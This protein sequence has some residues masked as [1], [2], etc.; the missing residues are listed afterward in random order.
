MGVASQF[1]RLTSRS[2][3]FQAFE[4]VR[5]R[6][7]CRGCDGVSL[8]SFERDLQ[9]QLDRI[10][11]R[12]LRRVYHP[13]PL[14]R[15]PI[16][17]KSGG[18]RFLSVPTVRDRIVQAAVYLVTQEIFEAEF[19]E[20][21]H[22]YRPGRSVRTA[23]AQIRELRDAGHRFVIDADIEGFFDNISHSLLLERL[24]YL[25]LEPYLLEMFERWVRAEVFRHHSI[26]RPT[27]SSS[28]AGE[29]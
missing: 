7:G 4:R 29:P 25:P 6:G 21:S 23:V 11:D 8:G 19:E 5:S 15:F 22:A 20:S 2:T 18:Q 12:L 13:L 9:R 14:L 26:S 17:K 24:S 1:D 27:W 28:T 10:Q 16:R 3:L